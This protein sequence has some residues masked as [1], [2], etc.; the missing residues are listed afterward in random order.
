VRRD[1][2]DEGAPRAEKSYELGA[3]VLRVELDADAPAA[4]VLVRQLL[5]D[6][7]RRRN[8]RSPR[9]AHTELVEGRRGFGT[10]RDRAHARE[11]AHDVAQKPR[12]LGETGEPAHALSGEKDDVIHRPSAELREPRDDRLDVA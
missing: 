10:S 4:E 9:R 5:D 7:F 6:P 11:R 8:A 3:G 2:L 1:R 12:S